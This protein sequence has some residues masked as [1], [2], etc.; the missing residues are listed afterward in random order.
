MSPTS[1][2]Q[3]RTFAEEC[4]ARGLL[5]LSGSQSDGPHQVHGSWVGGRKMY[6]DEWIAWLDGTPQ[7]SVVLH[8]TVVMQ[9]AAGNP[10]LVPYSDRM[11]LVEVAVR[12]GV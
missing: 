11:Y 4:A 12:N 6:S 5:D 1:K 10:A 9:R 7:R 2:V 8:R 3:G